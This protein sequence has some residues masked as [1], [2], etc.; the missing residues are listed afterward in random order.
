MK[1]KLFSESQIIDLFKFIDKDSKDEKL[2]N[3]NE[4]METLQIFGV[5]KNY[6]DDIFTKMDT[7]N[8][9]LISFDEFKTYINE[10]EKSLLKLYN[11]I[12][13]NKDGKLTEEEFKNSLSIVYPGKEFD[14][15]FI[16]NLIQKLDIDKDGTISFE[17][18]RNIL[19]FLPESN[20]NFLVEWS[21]EYTVLMSE[22][23][24]AFPFQFLSKDAKQ[25]G[26]FMDF[27]KNSLAGGIAAAISKTLTAPLD[28]LKTLY[29][30]SFYGFDKHPGILRGLYEIFKHDGFRGYFRG[31]FVNI[32]KSSPELSLRLASFDLLKSI[33]EKDA[34][35]NETKNSNKKGNLSPGVIF[36]M[37]A[38]AGIIS[39]YAVYPLSVVKTRLT[40]APTGTYKGIADCFIKIAKNEGKIKPFFSG[41]TASTTLIISGSGLS[42]MVMEMMRNSYKNYYQKKEIPLSSLMIIG[43]LSS[44]FTNFFCYPMQLVTTKMMMQ[45]LKGEKA[46]TLTLTIKIYRNQGFYGFYKGFFS[47]M[48]KVMLGNAISFSAYDKLQGVFKA[49]KN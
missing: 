19:V 36:I 2:I 47:L 33:F 20:M 1:Q 6:F 21:Q 26:N 31:N 22:L 45:G 38:I 49:S 8:D 43:A 39:S 32:L 48:N 46:S 7:N 25:K 44:G 3:A 27:L 29:Q 24:D 40:A 15:N 41:I 5:P 35:L 9:N 12:D 4:L 28:R 18:F 34:N 14:K 10:K 42:L 13:T 23:N 30:T 37:G 11:K 16:T 17:E